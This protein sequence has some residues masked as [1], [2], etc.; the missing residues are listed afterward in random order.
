MGS[1]G[2]TPIRAKETTVN[3]VD[4]CLISYWWGYQ[5]AARLFVSLMLTL[6]TTE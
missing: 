6:Y 2:P 4:M 1:T 3:Y 5:D